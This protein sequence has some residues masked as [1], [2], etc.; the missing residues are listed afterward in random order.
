MPDAGPDGGST[1]VARLRRIAPITVIS[2]APR[3]WS[4]WLRATWP[5]ADR[6]ALVKRKLLGL[7]FIHVARWALLTGLPQSAPRR[8]RNALPT[9][10]IVF[11]SNFDGPEEEY[12]EAFSLEVPGRVA[13]MWGRAYGFPGARR[14]RPFVDY[15]IGRQVPGPYHYYAAY[16]YGRVRT[17]RAALKL[18]DAFE[19]FAGEAGQLEPEEFAARWTVFLSEQQDNL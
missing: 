8:G 1:P 14:P 2:P 4:W 10:Y 3:W 7:N 17:A 13:G 15:V 9:P 19:Q 18:A 16:P 6:S 5:F 12:A 11:Q